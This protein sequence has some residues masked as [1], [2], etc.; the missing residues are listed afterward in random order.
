MILDKMKYE[1]QLIASYKFSNLHIGGS[2]RPVFFDISTTRP[3]LLDHDRN[4]DVVREELLGILPEKRAIPRYHKLDQMQFNIS[5]RVDPKPD[6]GSGFLER[7]LIERF[8]QPPRQIVPCPDGRQPLDGGFAP[9]A[10]PRF[11]LSGQV[12]LP[13]LTE[14]VLSQARKLAADR[15]GYRGLTRP[16]IRI[17]RG[18]RPGL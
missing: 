11:L 10:S 3:E 1:N 18:A 13:G 4:Y 6:T 5:A 12:I 16:I 17:S 14:S 8:G 15:S 7:F 2:R 9:S